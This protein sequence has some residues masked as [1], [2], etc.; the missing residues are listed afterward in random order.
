[1]KHDNGMKVWHIEGINNEWDTASFGQDAGKQS[2]CMHKYYLTNG[3]ALI[4]CH[5]LPC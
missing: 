5:L 1:M 4:Y 2:L 3:N